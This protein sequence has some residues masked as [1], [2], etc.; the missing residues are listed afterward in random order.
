V[1]FGILGPLEVRVGTGELIPVGGPR[2]RA[3]L[4]A[5]L[6]E[7]GRL[8]STDRLID[9]VYGDRP[10]QGAANALQA[11]I[12]RLRRVL[13]EIVIEHH[14]AGYRL[15]VDPD[16]VDA[17]RFTDLAAH[18]R[19][20]SALA[21]WRG[22]ALADVPG[23]DVER[24]RLTEQ[25][26]AAREDLAEARLARGAP[27][28]AI[29]DLRDLISAEPL[30][31]R[32][33]GQLMRAL[34]ALG[35]SA[36]A[37][38][39]FA[40][41]R[42]RLADELGADPSTELAD[43]HLAVLRADSAPT[44]IRPP[45]QLT[46]FVG[47]ETELVAVADRLRDSR[48]VTLV[49]PGGV[50]K[51][52]LAIE[53]AGEA[54]FVELAQSSGSVAQ[55]ILAALRLREAPLLL[56]PPNP[57]PALDRLVAALAERDLL[58][59]LDNCEHVLDE[60]AR[61]AHELLAACPNLRILA[62]S[63]E[64][65]GITGE[66]LYPV[67]PLP[68][69]SAARLFVDRARSVDPGF[70]A[71]DTEVRR[72]CVVLDGLPLAIELAAARLRSLSF[73]D[74][75]ARLDDRFTLLARGNRV[76]ARRHQTLRAVV[77]W[78]WDLLDE[79]ARHLA[80]R[81]A[82]FAGGATREAIDA[83]CGVPDADDVLADLVDQSLVDDSGRY[84]MLATIR[85]FCLEKLGPAAGVR[86]AH[87]EY[88]LALAETADPHLRRAEQLGWLARLTAEHDNLQAALH[89]A[90]GADHALALRLIGA[91]SGYWFLRGVRG[92]VAIVAADLLTRLDAP[93]PGLEQE[94]VLTV[95][96]ATAAGEVAAQHLT[97]ADALMNTLDESIRQPFLVVYWALT[98]GP[99]VRFDIDRI[100]PMSRRFVASDD[101][102]R[103][104]LADLSLNFLHWFGGA[105]AERA[106]AAC[107]RARDAF[108]ALGERWGLAQA[109]E[110][111]AVFAD[112]RG[113][114]V[115]AIELT[116][117]ALDLVGQLGAGEELAD[118]RCRRAERLLR[119][120]RITEAETDFRT[121]D[122]LARAGRLV[123]PLALA[124]RGLGELARG[125][126][127]LV[128]A[129]RWQE[130]ALRDCGTD[131]LGAGARARILTALGR[132]AEAEGGH[133]EAVRRHHEAIAVARDTRNAAGLADTIAGL[134][135][136]VAATEP[137]R[138]AQLL[139]IAR[140][141]GGVPP[142]G[143]PDLARAAS[144]LVT[145]LGPDR[146]AELSSGSPAT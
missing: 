92:D 11:Q 5:F 17:H 56:G 86:R 64:G 95:T 116:D 70:A 58:I 65:L 60:A 96:H 21:L 69:S 39:V 138:A 104:A 30:R 36:E 49:G 139:G 89:W 27:D 105:D 23:F 123:V 136:A 122:Q 47:R 106:E 102:W 46:G 77:D 22:P 19:Q 108:R 134:A 51:T 40:D 88:F 42:A 91:L 63:R 16:Q 100:A 99:P 143:D 87:A 66:A 98:T 59:V 32:P 37:L 112:E 34:H 61:C 135:G 4:A 71:D 52:R 67:R 41:L 1:R 82:V 109:V 94:Y 145:A 141:L 110:A 140:T 125:R 6:L 80:G 48:L 97:R 62:T 83:V 26:T 14:P 74:I 43:L 120:G 131:W 132:I 79:P 18:G 130:L 84:R 127:D 53:A 7:P 72:I 107:V 2:P 114:L 45:A 38:A 90:A 12:S 25:R 128:S 129:R 126:G 78:S 118:M 101:P 103:T 111:L 20:E 81:L 3:L 121:A 68:P 10:P 137:V 55:A 35:R 8:I 75:A 24:V 124:R 50:G 9:A 33:H 144:A 146:Y 119:A 29:A 76:A 142:R 13:P 57:A 44:P 117:E 93:V 28:T 54:C 85:L 15:V 113:E 115:R 31:E 133:A 73:A